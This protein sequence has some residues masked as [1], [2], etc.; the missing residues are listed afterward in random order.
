MQI[1]VR[2]HDLQRQLS[3]V[4]PTSF[5]YRSNAQCKKVDKSLQNKVFLATENNLLPLTK[6]S[7]QLGLK[8]RC[9]QL[10]ESRTEDK[11]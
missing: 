11:Y 10:L 5:M 4:F 8:F 2:D 7:L 9:R 1:K 3:A 6:T